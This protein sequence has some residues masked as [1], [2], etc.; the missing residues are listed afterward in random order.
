MFVSSVVARLAF[1]VTA[2][3]NWLKGARGKVDD[4][5]YVDNAAELKERCLEWEQ[6]CAN[7]GDRAR[8]RNCQPAW[9]IMSWRA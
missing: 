5:V 9:W 1:G 7:R 2:S 3:I 6:H 4:V 8:P